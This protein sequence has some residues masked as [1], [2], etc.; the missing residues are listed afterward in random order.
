MLLACEGSSS[1]A[2]YEM[3]PRTNLHPLRWAL[4]AHTKGEA[5]AVMLPL[6]L[7]WLAGVVGGCCALAA[8]PDPLA[9]AGV[10]LPGSGLTAGVSSALTA[11]P[12]SSVL[13]AAGVCPLSTTEQPA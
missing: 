9:A 8:S 3:R 12:A 10:S 6:L 5:D 7:S 2:E 13:T 1:V 11:A 4:Q